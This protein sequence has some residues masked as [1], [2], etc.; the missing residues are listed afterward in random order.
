[1]NDDFSRHEACLKFL[2][3]IVYGY[4]SPSAS[5]MH[6]A[7]HLRKDSNGEQLIGLVDGVAA[8]VLTLLVIEMPIIII[9]TVEQAGGISQIYIPIGMDI[10]GYFLISLIIYDIWSIQK[11]LFQSARSSASQNLTCVSTLWLSTLIPPILYVA[12]HFY[13]N[14]DKNLATSS[15]SGNTE[16]LV[17][18]TIAILIVLI[19]HAILYA[20]SL[21]KGLVVDLNAFNYSSKLLQLRVI[22]LAI[23]TPLSLAIGLHAQQ[24]H[25]LAPFLLFV[26]FLFVPVKPSREV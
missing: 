15:F 24:G 3:K 16:S 9:K 25:V 5:P 2:F 20:Y 17:F 18:R 23:I 13:R 11:S 22:A 14:F 4:L 21:K 7:Q 8:I 10:I 1:V 26:P 19:I 6:L 12:E